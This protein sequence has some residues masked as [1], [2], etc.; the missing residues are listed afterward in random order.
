MFIVKKELEIAVSHKLCLDYKSKCENLHGHNLKVTVYCQAEE[1]NDNNMV[2]DFTHIKEAVHSKLDHKNLND[3]L[4]FNPTAEMI[5]QW[6]V[7]NV[8]YCVAA[9][10]QESEGNVAVYMRDS[11][12]NV[13]I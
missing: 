4:D 13:T 11:N 8:D 1:L 3:V 7:E 12:L 5:A 6:I 9:K 10:V 2:V